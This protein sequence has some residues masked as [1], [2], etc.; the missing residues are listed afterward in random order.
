MR[1]LAVVNDGVSGDTLPELRGLSSL[2]QRLAADGGELAVEKQDG[3]FLTAARFPAARAD[4][5]TGGA[6]EDHR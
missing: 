5:A 4:A 6:A 1:C 3:R 2:R